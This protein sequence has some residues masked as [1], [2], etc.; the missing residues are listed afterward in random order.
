MSTRQE[1]SLIFTVEATDALKHSIRAMQAAAEQ[2]HRTE[3][4]ARAIAIAITNAET[5]LLWLERHLKDC[6]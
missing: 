3:V 1:T 5:S 6:S 2:I 4:N